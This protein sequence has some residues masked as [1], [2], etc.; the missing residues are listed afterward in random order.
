MGIFPYLD[1]LDGNGMGNQPREWDDHHHFS[2]GKST[3]NTGP[4]SIAMLVY[5]RV[6]II[7]INC[8]TLST[9]CIYI[10]IHIY[11]Y[12]YTHKVCV[13]DSFLHNNQTYNF[14]NNIY[15]HFF[16]NK[17]PCPISLLNL[18]SL[19]ASVFVDLVGTL[20]AQLSWL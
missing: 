2:M 9:E 4:C 14:A 16:E 8:I 18:T 12:I 17:L 5:Q 7:Y 1:E 10:H 20:G 15:S 13:Y 6:N 11:I 19:E 3:I